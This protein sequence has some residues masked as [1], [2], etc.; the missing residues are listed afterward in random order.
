VDAVP[1]QENLLLSSEEERVLLALAEP[2][3]RDDLIRTLGIPIRDANIILSAME[4]RGLIKES[5][6]LVMKL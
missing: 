6:G 5:L 3:S 2:L 1:S 4:L